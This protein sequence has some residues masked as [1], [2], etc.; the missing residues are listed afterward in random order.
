MGP[1][2]FDRPVGSECG[3]FRSDDGGLSWSRLTNGIPAHFKPYVDSIAVNPANPN[4]VALL[5]AE[6][7]IYESRDGG[8]QWAQTHTLPPARRLIF[9]G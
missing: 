8:D 2:G 7:H 5:G 9:V 4:Q 6:G 1:G 3:I